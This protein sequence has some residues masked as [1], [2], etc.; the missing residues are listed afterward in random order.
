MP[1]L[2][3]PVVAGVGGLSVGFFAGSTSSKFIKAAVIGGGLYVGYKFA[4]EV[5]YL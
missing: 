4:K 5:G 3:W 2:F 1:L